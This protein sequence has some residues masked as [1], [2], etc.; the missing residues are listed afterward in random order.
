MITLNNMALTE[1]QK[2]LVSLAD[3]LVRNA[4][5]CTFIDD[6]TRK[7]AEEEATV[8]IDDSV[9]RRLQ[10]YSYFAKQVPGCEE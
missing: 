2:R 10:D 4:K 9:A 8:L 1:R 5:P 6:M 3:E 7:I